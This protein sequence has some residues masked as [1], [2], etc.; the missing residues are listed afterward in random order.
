MFPPPEIACAPQGWLPALT[1]TCGRMFGEFFT[2]IPGN[3]G[4]RAVKYI[5]FPHMHWFNRSS[6]LLAPTN[7]GVELAVACCS[8][9][10]LDMAFHFIKVTVYN[11]NPRRRVPLSVD[12]V[13]DH[14]CLLPLLKCANLQEA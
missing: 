10:K 1:F 4:L 14:F 12:S 5:K 2:A 9:T 11:D 6:M 8:L 13:L 7:P 3:Y